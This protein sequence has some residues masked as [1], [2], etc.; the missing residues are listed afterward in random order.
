MKKKWMLTAIVS[1]VIVL[2][3]L[4]ALTKWN[5]YKKTEIVESIETKIST[6]STADIA[7]IEIYD[8]QSIVLKKQDQLWVNEEGNKL[9][10]EQDKINVMMD[11]IGQ[12]TSFQMISNV[13]DRSAYGI[14]ES[15]KIITIYD[16]AN[17]AETIRFGN[18]V[19]GQD[20]SYIWSDTDE[21]I[22][23]VAHSQLNDIFF[24]NEDIISKEMNIPAIAHIQQ[25]VITENDK[26]IKFVRNPKKG[27]P[28]YDTWLLEEAFKTTHEA[29]NE[30][31]EEYLEQIETFKREKFVT[32]DTKDLEV[33]GLNQPSLMIEI[34]GKY[35]IKFGKVEG[36]YIYFKYSGNPYIYKMLN[37]KVDLLKGINP[38]DL[39]R[40]EIYVPRIGSLKSIILKRNDETIE[41][42]MENP[43]KEHIKIEGASYINNVPMTL[44]QTETLLSAL[45]SISLYKPLVNPGFEE[46]QERTAEIVIAYQLKD[47]TTYAI[48]LIP[49][50]PSFY[51]LRHN[52]HVEFS[53][54]KK[55]VVNF[56][57]ELNRI[58]KEQQKE[59]SK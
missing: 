26:K 9:E 36:D 46:K 16:K 5:E 1:I 55:L 38:F 23:L 2:V 24:N 51:I 54:D 4:F 59:I 6:M 50:D 3:G 20:A 7:R 33:Y 41:W 32:T 29:N 57:N 58:V 34:N 31:V 14:N 39:I 47:D 12:M 22:Y 49:Y 15:S 43:D 27:T 48:E 44:E 42:T 18:V 40:K 30:L 53:V 35:T 19:S 45:G 28:K 52:G 25:I 8:G 37:E 21:V 56:F 11:E 10:Y 17:L 13:Q